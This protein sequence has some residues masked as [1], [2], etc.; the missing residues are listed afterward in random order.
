MR[1]GGD[2]L[3][4]DEKDQVVRMAELISTSMQVRRDRTYGFRP[5]PAANTWNYNPYVIHDPVTT[6]PAKKPLLWSSACDP[7]IFALATAPASKSAADAQF[8][9]Y[10]DATPATLRGVEQQRLG[11]S[12]LCGTVIPSAAVH[13]FPGDTTYPS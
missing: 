11:L 6:T 3:A 5:S 1:L 2:G 12:R 13:D 4:R 9:P 10:T 7:N 8:A